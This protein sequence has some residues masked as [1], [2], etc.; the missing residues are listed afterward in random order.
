MDIYI[1]FHVLRNL[2]QRRVL[3]LA[4]LCYFR[5]QRAWLLVTSSD[6]LAASLAL[7]SW[8]EGV[9]GQQGFPDFP[10]DEFSV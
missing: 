8:Y 7:P 3:F 2:G 1:F 6:R 4:L 9:P 5:L 10:T